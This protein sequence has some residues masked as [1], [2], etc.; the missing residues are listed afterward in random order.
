MRSGT[1]VRALIIFIAMCLLLTAYYWVHR[2]FGIGPGN[3]R[4]LAILRIGGALLDLL[5]T[6]VIFAAAGGLG[7]ALLSRLDMPS[8]A[9]RFALEGGIGLGVLALIVLA[10]G[11]IGWLNG[12]LFAAGLIAALILLR[13]AVIGWLR[14]GVDLLRGIRPENTAS[15]L[16]VVFAGVLLIA[17]LIM[18]LAPPFHWDGMTYHL[19]A[20]TRYLH[21]GRILAHADN[22]YLGLS[23]N[24]EMLYT[25]GIGL[26]GRDT[27]A[28][29]IHWGI[30]LLGLIGV[31]GLVRRFAGKA[32]A[33]LALLLLL[34][35]YNL[36]ALFGWSYVDL[37]TFLYGS[38]ALIAAVRWRE[39]RGR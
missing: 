16:I 4:P 12:I 5:T 29:P 10:L 11:L 17:A 2:P 6:G 21:D 1:L 8:R 30:G 18:A 38:L 26:F 14:D 22:F 19:I 13:R 37:G 32:S 3:E 24:V 9:E 36:W 25:L 23:Q 31:A 35:A 34:S 20:P 39:T 15:A 28:A 7:R 33:W 27:A